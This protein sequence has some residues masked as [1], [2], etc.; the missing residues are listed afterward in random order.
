MTSSTS[1]PPSHPRPAEGM[2]RVHCHLG[3][4]VLRQADQPRVPVCG[5][6]DPAEVLVHYFREDPLVVA[7]DNEL[8][9]GVTLGSV[10]ACCVIM[11][12]SGCL[13]LFPE[14]LLAEG[15]VTHQEISRRVHG[16]AK[17]PAQV[18]LT[19][20]RGARVRT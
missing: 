5:E 10:P 11:G 19:G 9:R 17:S 8:A 20:P 3:H 2:V 1:A 16:N 15:R 12:C 4:P 13:D 14:R 6:I 7:D 18:I